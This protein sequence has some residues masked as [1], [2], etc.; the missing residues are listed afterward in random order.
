M[1]SSGAAVTVWRTASA[2]ARWPAARGR[3][4]RVPQRPLPSMMIATW[5]EVLCLIK[6]FRKKKEPLS[7][8]ACGTDQRFHVVEIALERPPAE[9]GEAVFRLGDAPGERLGAGDV[10]RVLEFAR[11]DAQVAIRGLEQPLE[12]VERETL[13]H[14]QGAHDG[15]P[16]ALV[17]QPVELGGGG[18]SLRLHRPLRFGAREARCI[19]LSH[20]T[21]VR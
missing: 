15:E 1:P 11:M 10:F 7:A 13:A 16:D 2:P 21:S 14:R 12:L 6:S 3:P 9:G 4:R 8:R 18:L 19:A 5:R 20:R 17:D